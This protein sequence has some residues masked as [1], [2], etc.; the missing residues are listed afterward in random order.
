MVFRVVTQHRVHI[1]EDVTRVEG[2]EVEREIKE[3]LEK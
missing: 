2:M 1:C 3:N